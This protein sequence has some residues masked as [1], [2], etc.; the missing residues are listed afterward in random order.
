MKTYLT[1]TFILFS[2]CL[3]AQNSNYLDLDK[4]LVQNDK[5]PQILLVGSFHFNYSGRDTH[6]T[7]TEDRIDIMSEKRQKELEELLEYIARFKPT[8]I[9]VEAGR[10]TGYLHW[11]LKDSKTGEDKLRASETDQIGLRLMDRF[12]LDTIYGVNDFSYLT[13]RN[14]KRSKDELPPQ[15]YL[16]S[17]FVEHHYDGTDKISNRYKSSLKAQDKFFAQNTLLES[18]SHLNSDIALKR[19]FGSYIS[20][21]YFMSEGQ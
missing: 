8:K 19:N 14:Y 18:F 7:K 1:Y 21:G 4:I 16:D 3:F 10:N 20:G 5:R 12:K 6:K 13:R 11:R 9:A 2:A 15:N 17:L